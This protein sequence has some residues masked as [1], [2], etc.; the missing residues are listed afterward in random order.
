MKWTIGIDL[1]PTAGGALAFAR[2][3][4]DTATDDAETELN[5]VHVL[6]EAKLLQDLHHLH[7]SEVEERVLNVAQSHL[8]KVGLSFT[9]VPVNVVQ[10]QSVDRSMASEARAMGAHALV[11]GRRAAAHQDKIVR[12]GRIARRLLRSLPMPIVVVPPNMHIEDFGAGPIVLA[13][14]LSPN[15][16]GA[17]KFA[18]AMSR[19]LG[20]PLVVAHVV[21]HF[22]T[23][24]AY[25]PAATLD[26]LYHQLGLQQGEQL[27]QWMERHELHGT[28]TVLA[29]GDVVSRVIGIADREKSP[30]I[31]CGSRQLSIVDR[32]F[33]ASV[34]STFSSYSD[35]PIAVVP[36]DAFVPV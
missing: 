21:P 8:Q 29:T 16:A 13:T 7:L 6:E 33:T 12:L 15:A 1:Q 5:A 11:I 28:P 23:A 26:Q 36:P 4:R 20:R 22:D 32:V 31:V 18:K 14:D 2:W 3:I 24:T 9:D 17:A 19:S 35:R 30:L 25:V 10:G 27:G 34:S